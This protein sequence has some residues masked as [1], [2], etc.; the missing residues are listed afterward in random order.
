MC[1]A[2]AAAPL[3][4]VRVLLPSCS[5]IRSLAPRLFA[6]P[7]PPSVLAQ[8]S[9]PRSASFC[10]PSSPS[11]RAPARSAAALPIPAMCVLHPLALPS[12]PA[13]IRRAGTSAPLRALARA[14]PSLPAAPSPSPPTHSAAFRCSPARSSFLSVPSCPLPLLHPHAHVT[15]RAVTALFSV[16]QPTPAC[17]PSH[18]SSFHLFH[19][20]TRITLTRSLSTCLRH[21]PAPVPEQLPT[22]LTGFLLPSS[23][24]RAAPLTRSLA[25]CVGAAAASAVASPRSADIEIVLF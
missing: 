3:L 20:V 21:W 25:P 5:P 4:G 2:A 1:P 13:P 10:C 24:Q 17:A 19:S 15:S 16:A 23:P 12:P 14:V 8:P 22:G 18:A 6:A 9:L 7:V 11:C